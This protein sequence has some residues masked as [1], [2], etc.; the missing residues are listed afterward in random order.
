MEAPMGD[1]HWV[2]WE[3]ATAVEAA[4]AFKGDDAVE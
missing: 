1:L 2:V 4:G 3:D